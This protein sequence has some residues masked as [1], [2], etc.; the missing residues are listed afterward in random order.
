M[1]AN[2]RRLRCHRQ[3]DRGDDR[4]LQARKISGV[5][6]RLGFRTL[7]DAPEVSSARCASLVLA[8][9]GAH[10][11]SVP[12]ARAGPIGAVQSER[13]PVMPSCRLVASAPIHP[14][15]KLLI[16]SLRRCYSHPLPCRL[17]SRSEPAR[18]RLIHNFAHTMNR[19]ALTPPVAAA[20][21]GRA[22]RG[23]SPFTDQLFPTMD[24]IVVSFP[25]LRRVALFA[26]IFRGDPWIHHLATG[27]TERHRSI[28]TS[29]IHV[30]TLTLRHEPLSPLR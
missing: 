21:S 24:A 1:G 29:M 6:C 16:R 14:F 11:L 15:V 18:C 10:L 27:R 17:P 9:G 3:A 13:V 5:P 12:R 22:P 30:G 26:A 4:S 20:A 25:S 7:R 23:S 28:S 19:A 8:I 2:V